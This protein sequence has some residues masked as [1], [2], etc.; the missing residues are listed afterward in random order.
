M[1]FFIIFMKT[2]HLFVAVS[3]IAPF[4]FARARVFSVQLAAHDVGRELREVF[5]KILVERERADLDFVGLVNQQAVE[6]S[7]SEP[8]VIAFG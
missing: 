1:S 3:D 4:A 6:T 2:F 5:Y 8:L 7:A